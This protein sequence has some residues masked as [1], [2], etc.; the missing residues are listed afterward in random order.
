MGFFSSSSTTC[1]G[2]WEAAPPRKVMI[3]NS[4]RVE[5]VEVALLPYLPPQLG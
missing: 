5:V 4:R 1:P 3:L 2:P